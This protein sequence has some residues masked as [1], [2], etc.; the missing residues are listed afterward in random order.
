M[1]N[2]DW[3]KYHWKIDDNSEI[4][5]HSMQLNIIDIL[6]LNAFMSR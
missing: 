2:W 3:K 5:N 6:L 4:K 1:F